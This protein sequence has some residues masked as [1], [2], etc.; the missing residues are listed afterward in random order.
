M[1]EEI[2]GEYF[3]PDGLSFTLISKQI[4]I[5][6]TQISDGH[7]LIIGFIKKKNLLTKR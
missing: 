5:L 6:Y 2:C 7:D 4:F 3:V 1:V